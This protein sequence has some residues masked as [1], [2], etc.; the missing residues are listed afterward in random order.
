VDEVVNSF[1]E[2]SEHIAPEERAVALVGP[3]GEL[4]VELVGE[5]PLSLSFFGHAIRV[6]ARFRCGSS[7]KGEGRRL[8][9]TD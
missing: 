2:S 7:R 1:N 4:V 3:D 9:A 5:P 6:T 8:V